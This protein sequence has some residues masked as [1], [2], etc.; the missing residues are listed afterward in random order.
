MQIGAVENFLHLL[1]VFC[2]WYK[3]KMVTISMR[4]LF[5]NLYKEYASIYFPLNAN[6]TIEQPINHQNNLAW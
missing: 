1:R 6:S 2:F 3:M 4:K 5:V